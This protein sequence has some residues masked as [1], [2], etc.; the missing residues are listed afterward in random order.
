VI[1]RVRR[2]SL[3]PRVI[4]PAD[5][6]ILV[7]RVILAVRRLILVPR[8]ILA[9]RR[10]SPVRKAILAARR[11]IVVPRVIL[12]VRRPTPV[13]RAQPAGT[14]SRVA[15]RNSLPSSQNAGDLRCLLENFDRGHDE[16]G[17]HDQQDGNC[18][19]CECSRQTRTLY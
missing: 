9:A 7:R 6:S 4:L 10:P 11:L 2:S 16:P 12:R 14:R 15:R 19:C 18:R 3:V 5:P 1:L 17:L 8:V 13:R